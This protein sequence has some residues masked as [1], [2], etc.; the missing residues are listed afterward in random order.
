MRRKLSRLEAFG[1]HDPSESIN[2]LNLLPIL[3]LMM[4]LIPLLIGKTAFFDLVSLEAELPNIRPAS[5]VPDS[6]RSVLLRMTVNPEA[7]VVEIIDEQ[8]GIIVSSM[9]YPQSEHGL[10]LLARSLASFKSKY[11]R[12]DTAAVVVDP[13]AP[14]KRLVA[15][16]QS[17]STSSAEKT[18]LKVVVIPNRGL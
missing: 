15:A 16:L 14:Y 1:T 5:E 11:P 9:N 6:Q 8:S 10:E 17:F 12:L 4:L 7:E 13:A 2:D 3:S 18:A